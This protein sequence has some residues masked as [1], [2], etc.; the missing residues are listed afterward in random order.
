MSTETIKVDDD[1]REDLSFMETLRWGRKEFTERI[2]AASAV[3]DERIVKVLRLE[4][5]YQIAEFIYLLAANEINTEDDLRRLADIHSKYVDLLTKDTMKMSRLGLTRERLLDAI[6]TADTLPRLL[7]NW[8]DYPGSIDQSNLARLLVTVMSSETCRKVVVACEK[9][10]FL[11]R[12]RTSY[13][14]M[15]VRST[16]QMERIFGGCIREMRMHLQQKG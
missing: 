6:F 8:R 15:L 11:Q 9:A 12:K 7:E 13:G 16:G 3:T 2:C 5:T 1:L 10:G 14:T 4:A